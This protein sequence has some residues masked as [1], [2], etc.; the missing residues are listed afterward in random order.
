MPD[1][2][3]ARDALLR[4]WIAAQGRLIHADRPNWADCAD[5]IRASNALGQDLGSGMVPP[6]ALMPTFA[7][8]Q[9]G[10]TDA[11]YGSALSD[12]LKADSRVK[13]LVAEAWATAAGMCRDVDGKPESIMR[14][15]AAAI[16]TAHEGLFARTEYL[17]AMISWLR[18]AMEVGLPVVPPTLPIP[19]APAIASTPKVE[20]WRDGRVSLWH[21]AG[22]SGAGPPL[23]IVHGLIGRQ[24]MVDLEPGRSL[25]AEMIASGTDLWVLDWGYPSGTDRDQGFAEHS[26]GWIGRAVASL[27]EASGRA[28]AVLGICQG[29]LFVLCHAAHHAGDLAGIALTGTPVDFHADL[30]GHEGY[31][32]R[33]ARVLPEDVIEGL[34]A[35]TGFLPGA[36]TGTLFQTMTPGR[37]FAKYTVD[38]AEK[39]EDPAAMATFAR[40]EAWLSDRPDLPGLAARE[41]LMDLYKKNALI[42]GRFV[43]SGRP[44]SLEDIGCPVLNIVA[45]HD[46]IVPPACSLALGGRLPGARYEELL[47]P[48]GHIGV[49]VSHRA[50]GVV[51]RRLSAWLDTLSPAG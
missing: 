13:L 42:H 33:L 48:S 41:W 35:P 50:K 14:R 15:W 43:I 45:N 10:A 6:D 9:R 34:I 29:G 25:V 12:L 22:A 30:A 49:F 37:T 3:P 38:L 21:Y 47:V 51:A 26:D 23:L 11:V 27:R 20:V 7:L 8:T 44:V 18:A 40:M 4:E 1:D 28:P 32:N 36:L 17:E 46:H 39:L 24:T 5:L 2:G 16:D 19:P 31:L